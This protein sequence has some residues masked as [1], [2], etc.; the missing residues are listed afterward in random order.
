MSLSYLG[1]YAEALEDANTAIKISPNL[2][3]AFTC[4][5]FVQLLA[6][7]FSKSIADYSKLISLGGGT[8]DPDNFL[9]RGEA[10]FYLGRLEEAADDFAK[11]SE[12]SDAEGRLYAD[13][14]L[15]W[16]LQRLGKPVPDAVFERASAEVG[17]EWPRPAL[18]LFAGALTPE[19]LLQRIE[20]KSGDEK[21]MMLAE[22]YFYLGQYYFVRG[23]QAKARFYFEKTR[24]LEVL[25]YA[26][27]IAS[28]F[29]LQRMNAAQ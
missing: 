29:E 6:G 13:L 26:E 27:H 21:Q 25:V 18:A 7:E 16:T 9:S 4:R 10:K 14:W 12:A 1:K 15:I 3:K 23:D 28:G 8:R 11:A 20:A 2:F 24:Q 17:G 5:G 22:G 19:Q